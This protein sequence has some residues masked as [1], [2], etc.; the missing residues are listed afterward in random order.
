MIDKQNLVSSAASDEHYNDIQPK[1][2]VIVYFC[3]GPFLWRP[4]GT[5]PVCLVLNPA[6]PMLCF[7]VIY[8]PETVSPRLDTLHVYVIFTSYGVDT[9]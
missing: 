6:L 8:S 7:G 1:Y 4:L 2:F 3:G 9:S 5:C